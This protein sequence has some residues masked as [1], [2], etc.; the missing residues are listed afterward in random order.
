MSIL[1]KII[2][3][4]QTEIAALDASTLRRAAESS[5]VPRDFLAAIKRRRFGTHPSLIAE[6][7]RASPSKGILAPHLDLLIA[8]AEELQPT[9]LQDAPVVA[10]AVESLAVALDERGGGERDELRRRERVHGAGRVPCGQVRG[11]RD[12]V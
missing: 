6:L 9:V 1:E 10:G 2:E 12:H 4:K 11:Q 8:P 5:P 3:H 7:K